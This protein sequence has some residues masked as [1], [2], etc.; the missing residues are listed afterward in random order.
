MAVHLA[1][2]LQGLAAV[3]PTAS[4]MLEAAAK[5]AF[6]FLRSPL[7]APAATPYRFAMSCA[8]A[9]T[10]SCGHTYTL[11]VMARCI[12]NRKLG[13]G[14]LELDNR[15]GKGSTHHCWLLEINTTAG[16][17]VSGSVYGFQGVG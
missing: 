2:L 4:G 17:H 3:G 13:Q 11:M 1:L 9:F 10:T 7:L 12:R 8:Y 14:M 16:R 6:R 5:N 15:R